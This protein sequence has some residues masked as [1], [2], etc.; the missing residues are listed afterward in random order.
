MEVGIMMN[1]SW[2]PNDNDLKGRCNSA[3][4][5]HER[6][7]K[8]LDVTTMITSWAFEYAKSNK[9]EREGENASNA[10]PNDNAKLVI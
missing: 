5:K 1:I 10:H 2:T 7:W 8:K 9:S 3:A 4:N 6:S